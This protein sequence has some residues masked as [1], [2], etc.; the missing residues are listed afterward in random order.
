MITTGWLF[1]T[2]K[3][4]SPDCLGAASSVLGPWRV[5]FLVKVTQQFCRSWIYWSL[6]ETIGS[7][8][9]NIPHW[10]MQTPAQQKQQFSH[11][12]FGITFFKE[13]GKNQNGTLRG[14]K[15]HTASKSTLA[16]K[17]AIMWSFMHTSF[18]LKGWKGEK[19]VSKA[20]IKKNQK[21]PYWEVPENCWNRFM[22]L[23]P[24]LAQF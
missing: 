21:S 20:R 23:L 17:P 6:I 1:W 3:L 13:R 7:V 8:L 18:K 12:H 22:D 4:H 11:H 19:T 14:Q 10:C 16:L 5:L 15:F 9:Q 2:S 24:I